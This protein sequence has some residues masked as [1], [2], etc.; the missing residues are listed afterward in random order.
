MAIADVVAEIDAKIRSLGKPNCG[1]RLGVVLY[2]DLCAEGHIRDSTFAH[3]KTSGIASTKPAYKGRHIVFVDP[4][5]HPE[6]FDV[7]PH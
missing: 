1:L 3:P 7:G 2:G 4:N 6:E 5:M